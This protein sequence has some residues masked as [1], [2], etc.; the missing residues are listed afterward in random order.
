MPYRPNWTT[1]RFYVYGIECKPLDAS[2]LIFKELLI[3]P[4]AS[5]YSNILL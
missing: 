1:Q 2:S 5:R 4:G 3:L